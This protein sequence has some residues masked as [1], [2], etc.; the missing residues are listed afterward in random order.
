MR[1]RQSEM[2]SITSPHVTPMAEFWALTSMV[3]GMSSVIMR[4]DVTRGKVAGASLPF[5]QE[6]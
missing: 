3:H 4:I 1:Y 2:L 5:D 6:T